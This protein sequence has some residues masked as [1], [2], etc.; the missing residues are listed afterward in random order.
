LQ[1]TESGAWDDASH[2]DPTDLPLKRHPFVAVDARLFTYVEEGKLTPTAALLYVALLRYHNPKRADQTVWPSRRALAK[3]VGIRKVDNI[4]RH[5]KALKDAG[6][7]SWTGR[8]VGKMKASNRYELHLIADV[9]RPEGVPPPAGYRAP[10]Q[11]GTDPPW[12]G[13]ELDTGELPQDEQDPRKE[14]KRTAPPTFASLSSA[15]ANEETSNDFDDPWASANVKDLNEDGRVEDWRADDRA[16]FKSFVGNQLRTNGERWGKDGQTFTAE[17][18]Y[19]AFRLKARRKIKW[20]GRFLRKLQ[21]D[22]LEVE[23][24]LIDQGLE[25]VP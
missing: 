5:L 25:T 1:D 13:D 19:N 2:A 16:L 23:D 17:A 7:I 4:D 24:W 21:D 8:S 10:A 9:S 11:R 14:G 22:G 6:L 3:A 20:P 12:T 15:G 18:F